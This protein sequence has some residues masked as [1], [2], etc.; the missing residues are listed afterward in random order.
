[1]NGGSTLGPGPRYGFKTIECISSPHFFSMAAMLHWLCRSSQNRALLPKYRPSRTAVSAVIA[2]RPLRMSVMRP[3]GT[4]RS[5]ESRFVLSLRACNSRR[6][7]RPGCT[8]GTSSF[9]IVD[10]FDVIGI[11]LSEFKANAPGTV[12]GHCPLPFSV[13]FQFMQSD[14]LER[15]KVVERLGYIQSQQQID[16]GLEV[17]TAK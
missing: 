16:S 10:D 9:V 1:M 7:K 4:P 15:A 13:T 12:D 2:R 11:A 5:S 8:G 17:E 6:S 3:D 14:A